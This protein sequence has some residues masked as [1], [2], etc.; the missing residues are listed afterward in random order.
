MEI[1]FS[2]EN[3]NIVDFGFFSENE[4]HFIKED[5]FFD[6]VSC[7][8]IVIESM[9]EDFTINT[10]NIINNELVKMEV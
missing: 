7:A 10:Y 4:T 9:P 6:K 5:T 1:L 2:K 3:N 8:K